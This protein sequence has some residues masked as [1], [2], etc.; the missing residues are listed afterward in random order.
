ME[1]DHFQQLQAMTLVLGELYFN[2]R[3]LE[4]AHDKAMQTAEN[5][6]AERKDLKLEIERL[7]GGNNA[8]N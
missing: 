2:F 1:T 4:D 7:K 3:Q 8:G 6:E 5:L